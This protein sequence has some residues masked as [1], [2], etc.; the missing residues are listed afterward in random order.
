VTVTN[1]VDGAVVPVATLL[2]NTS[3]YT[4]PAAPTPTASDSYR[5]EVLAVGASGTSKATVTLVAPLP[6]APTL[7]TVTVPNAR[8]VSL[9]WTNTSPQGVTVTNYKI[10]YSTDNGASWNTLATTLT[11]TPAWT[12][13]NQPLSTGRTYLFRVTAISGTGASALSSTPSSTVKLVYTVPGSPT[14][15]AVGSIARVGTTNQD[16]VTLNWTAPVVPA[17][18]LPL[19]SY[20]VQYSTNNGGNWTSVTGLSAATST[21]V[22]NVSRGI[23]GTTKY[24]FRI[25]AVNIAGNGGNSNT[26]ANVATL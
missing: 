9:T 25:V 21:A 16:A 14:S 4:D 18:G 8:N 7:N 23:V 5:Y 13:T 24:S 1:G 19:T 22:V 10:E 11:N 26:T 17:N 12:T 6:A 3:S 15:L 2:A 20:T